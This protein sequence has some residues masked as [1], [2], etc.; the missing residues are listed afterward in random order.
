M[1]HN[2][3]LGA[4]VLNEKCHLLIDRQG[5][6]IFHSNQGRGISENN[7]SMRPLVFYVFLVADYENRG[8]INF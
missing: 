4:K 5:N 3:L 7:L 2:I 8:L 6:L 1:S